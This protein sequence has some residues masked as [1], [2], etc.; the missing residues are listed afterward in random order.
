[1]GYTVS[2][3]LQEGAP[4]EKLV[5][6]IEESK[7][8]KRFDCHI[9]G[10]YIDKNYLC[11]NFSSLGHSGMLFLIGLIKIMSYKYG[12]KKLNP[13]DG[14]SYSYYYYDDETCL[15]VEKED[16]EKID[17]KYKS[18]Y[19]YKDKLYTVDE[20]EDL[21]DAEKIQNF[22]YIIFDYDER[23]KYESKGTLKNFLNRKVYRQLDRLE[24][25]I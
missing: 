25:V 16:Y 18:C 17:Q 3:P 23:Q 11:V 14:K 13:L 22:D 7:L 5:G 24:R 4:T 20:F 10:V 19:L 6:I 8:L 15:I 1:M 12:L 2:L 9:K 21:F